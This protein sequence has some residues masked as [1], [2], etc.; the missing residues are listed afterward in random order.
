MCLVVQDIAGR[1]V[2]C[3]AWIAASKKATAG[4]IIIVTV[5]ISLQVEVGHGCILC[6]CKDVS[7]LPRLNLVTSF[8]AGLV[9]VWFA[10]DP[11]IF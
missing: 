9:Q 7:S 2:E 6:T 8:S 11:R 4:N 3:H 1:P 10:I 5:I